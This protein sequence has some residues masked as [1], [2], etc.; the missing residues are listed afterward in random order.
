MS[1]ETSYEGPEKGAARPGRPFVDPRRLRMRMVRD[2]LL[3][4]GIRDENVLSAMGAL[5]RHLFV[6]EALAAHAYEDSA[7]P[8][9]YGQTIS[10]PYMVARMLELLELEKGM[11]VLEVGAGSGYQTALLA[12]MGCV[13]HGVERLPGLYRQ[14]SQLLRRMGI[15]GAHLHLGDGTLGLPHLAPFDRIIVAAGGP[16]IPPPL[17]EQLANNGIMLIPVGARPRSQRL[18]R[19]RKFGDRIAAEDAGPA[20]F[21]NLVGSHG[22]K[23]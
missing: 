23:S 3:A 12:A 9:G 4:R 6:Q 17:V 1:R 13:A 21:V 14:T 16:E 22:W 5:P 11:R 19:L 10:Q 15:R 2:Q 8:I 20:V 7:L 18:A